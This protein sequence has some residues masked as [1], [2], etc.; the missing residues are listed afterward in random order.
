MH[1]VLHLLTNYLDISH[2]S[3]LGCPTFGLCF[4]WRFG[5]FWRFGDLFKFSIKNDLAYNGIVTSQSFH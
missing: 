3:S 4:A 2:I 5:D 1:L